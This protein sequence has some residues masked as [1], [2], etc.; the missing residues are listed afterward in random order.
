MRGSVLGAD[1]VAASRTGTGRWL[2]L[3]LRG[4]AVLGAGFSVRARVP[5][6][7]LD[8]QRVR[9]G[10]GDAGLAVKYS[11][12]LRPGGPELSAGLSA[13]APTGDAR[14]GLG[15][16]HVSLAPV[17]ALTAPV[18][19]VGTR[20]EIAYLA[21]LGSGHGSGAALPPSIGDHDPREVDATFVAGWRFGRGLWL[22][23]AI[24]GALSLESGPD[25]VGSRISVL[26]GILW[27]TGR[28]AL[29]ATAEVPLTSARTTDLALTLSS[30]WAL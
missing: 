19:P 18:G 30:A 3:A 14:A 23:G 26:P 5:F 16:G 11:T 25:R 6:Y 10:L 12:R 2:G 8:A 24:T 28:V 29:L 17:V 15:S 7:V 22:R 9:A 27:R 20:L 13:E 21:A 1:L 4:E